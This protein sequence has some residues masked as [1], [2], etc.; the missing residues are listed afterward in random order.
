MSEVVRPVGGMGRAKGDDIREL[1]ALT[2]RALHMLQ[3][4]FARFLGVSDRTMRRWETSGTRFSYEMLLKVTTA[5]HPKDPQLAER[6]AAYHGLTLA[7]LGLGL[8]P[9]EAVAFGILRAAAEA[10]QSWPHLMRPVLAATFEHA[11]A[12][13]LTM[14]A[15]HALFAPQSSAKKK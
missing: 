7:D 6:L 11:R 2:L 3:I 12:A 1:L 15:A 4:E 14:E 8:T 10:N 13:G 9:D 5:L